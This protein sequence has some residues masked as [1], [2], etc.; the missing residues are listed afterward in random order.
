MTMPALSLGTP[1]GPQSLEI[2]RIGQDLG[3]P[4]VWLFDS[5][6]LYEDIWIWLDRIG[7]ETDIGLGTA[8]LVPNLRH[9]M[10]TASAIA[11]I[12]HSYPG[13]LVVGFGT[14]A[15]ARWVLGKKALSWATTRTY[16]ENL[17]GLLA[18]EVVE[19]DGEKCQMIHWPGFTA[20]RPIRTPILLSAMGPKGHEI[21]K[22]IADGI[23]TVGDEPI[24][25][26]WRVDMF[27]GTAIVAGDSPDSERAREAVAPWGVLPYHG[28]HAAAPEFLDLMPKGAEWRA[29]IEAARP[30]GE[31][32]LA[33]HYGH[34]TH[35]N[36]LDRGL[37]LEAAWDLPML[38]R[39]WIGTPDE[40]RARAEQAA[41]NGVTELL[42]TPCGPDPVGEAR[43]MAEVFASS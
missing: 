6:A 21:T 9:V 35:V 1:P 8:V 42:Y 20:E 33:V 22:E 12:E 23:I 34:A 25:I 36:D 2:A 32:H 26:H 29:A 40:L 30:E 4:R 15:T 11:T 3:C 5:A 16:I 19:V 27:F 10:T 17:R 14:G 31:R 38:Q 18:G 37:V 41:A 39:A 13:R 28:C 7:R 43:R 24:D